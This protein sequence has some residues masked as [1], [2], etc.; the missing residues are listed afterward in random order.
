M[1]RFY[2]NSLII[3]VVSICVGVCMT[4]AGLIGGGAGI[5]EDVLKGIEFYEKI[6]NKEPVNYIYPV[7]EY[8]IDNLE[9]NIDASDL[10]IKYENTDKFTITVENEDEHDCRIDGDTL[11][12][13]AIGHSEAIIKKLRAKVTMVFPE[14]YKFNDVKITLGAGRMKAGYLKSKELFVEVGA[15]SVEVNTLSVDG[16][17]LLTVGAGNMEVESLNAVKNAELRVEAGNMEVN[18]IETES[19]DIV[20]EAGRFEGENVKLS[21][22]AKIEC[23]AGSVSLD[24]MH[25]KEDFNYDLECSVGSISFGDEKCSGLDR[26]RRIENNADKEFDIECS[27]GAVEIEFEG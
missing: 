9:L 3:A 25:Q 6:E 26:E 4:L 5:L 10:I 20:C 15:G 16:D 18:G 2:K 1:K 19:A 14:N 11:K 27:V 17:A 22:N 23:G 7:G 21:S 24:M 8:A 12:F 13:E